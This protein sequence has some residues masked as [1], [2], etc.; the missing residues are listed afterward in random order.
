MVIENN[1][2]EDY[3][4]KDQLNKLAQYINCGVTGDAVA[5]GLANKFELEACNEHM[6][7]DIG[8]VFVGVSRGY[9]DHHQGQAIHMADSRIH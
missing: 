6:L 3:F 8:V 2:Y 7:T 9:T 5:M 4:N 1:P